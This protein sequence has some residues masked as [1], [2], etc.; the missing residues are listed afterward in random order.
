MLLRFTQRLGVD[1]HLR[2]VS[3]T[4]THART[5]IFMIVHLDGTVVCVHHQTPRGI[6]HIYQHSETFILPVLKP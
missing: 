4:H 5:I 3:H 6:R 2:G 1:R